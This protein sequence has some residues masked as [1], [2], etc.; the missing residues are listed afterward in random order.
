[1]EETKG[2]ALDADILVAFLTIVL[3]W[4]C[5]ERS[6]LIITP[7]SLTASEGLIVTPLEVVIVIQF[8]SEGKLVKGVVLV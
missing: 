5:H 2:P 6:E 7:R 3:M 8:R 4:R 1:M